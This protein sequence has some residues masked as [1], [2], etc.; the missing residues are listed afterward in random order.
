MTKQELRDI[1]NGK[2][3]AGEKLVNK[4]TRE[5]GFVLP[6]KDDTDDL[7]KNELAGEVNRLAYTLAVVV[8]EYDKQHKRLV[9]QK[10]IRNKRRA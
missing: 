2:L 1:V 3:T 7:T 4:I 9:K 10:I 5:E 6:D 8:T